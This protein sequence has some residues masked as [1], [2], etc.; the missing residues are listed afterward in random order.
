MAREPDWKFEIRNALRPEPWSK[1]GP[2]RLVKVVNFRTLM[3]TPDHARAVGYVTQELYLFGKTPT[4]IERALGLP[5]FRLRRGCR[6]FE[7]ERLPLRGEYSDELTA[8]TP[9]GLAFDLGDA[10]EARYRYDND[11]SMVEVP[12]YPPGDRWIPQWNV[13]AAIPLKHIRDLPPNI[14]YPRP[15][16]RY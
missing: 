12:Y 9:G 1:D 6:V 10:L 13:T 15:S 8:D 16:D 7:L 4:D 11:K 3:N 5:P 14:T 2:Q